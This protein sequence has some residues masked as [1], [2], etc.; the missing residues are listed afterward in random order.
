MKIAPALL[1]SPW[2]TCSTPRAPSAWCRGCSTPTQ[3]AGFDA[4]EPREEQER[5]REQHA[6][7][8]RAAAAPLREAARERRLAIDWRRRRPARPAFTGRRGAV[9]TCR[10]RRSSRTSTGRSSSTPGSCKGKFPADPRRPPPRRGRAR[11][12]RRR[13]RRCSTADRRRDAPDRAAASTASGRRTPTATTSCSAPTTS[14]QA[15]LARFPM[16]RQQRR[17]GRE[18]APATALA[19][20]VAPLESG[21]LD[22]VGA[23]AVTAGIG[24][25]E[26][27][28]RV[29][30]RRTTTTG[31]IMV[32]ALADRLAEAFAE[33]L[34]A[35]RAPRLGLRRRRG[36][37]QRG[38][39]RRE[40][41]RHPP[42]VRL[43]GLPRP[44]REA[45]LFDAARRRRDRDR[46]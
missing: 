21:L 23:F 28:A 15:R 30:G 14:A 46:A 31:A 33:M 29:R 20:F 42:G 5:L 38:P 37:E 32:K 2:S 40:V 1:A 18:Q 8:A 26:L 35:A 44:H 19:D 41:P 9:E 43:P 11:A 39:D 4:D 45:T 7:A 24:A 10:W 22:Y 6:A 16:L 34:H 17:Q 13:A 36:P 3:R 12:V 27:V 25:D